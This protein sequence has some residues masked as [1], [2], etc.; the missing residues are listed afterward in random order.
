M[1]K[2]GEAIDSAPPPK[3]HKEDELLKKKEVRDLR[4]SVKEPSR[5]CARNRSREGPDAP[6]RSREAA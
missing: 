3:E 2:M 1:E 6:D 5:R 4:Q